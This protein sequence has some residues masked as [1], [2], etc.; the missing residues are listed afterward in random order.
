MSSRRS[1]S[2]S[3][4]PPKGLLVIRFPQP[5]KFSV[6]TF[7]AR[8]ALST[9]PPPPASPGV[10]VKTSG[11]LDCRFIWFS[12]KRHA[13][14]AGERQVVPDTK[15]HLVFRMLNLGGPVALGGREK[16]PEHSPLESCAEIL[17]LEVPLPPLYRAVIVPF[18]S[19]FPPQNSVSLPIKGLY[20]LSQFCR[21]W[22]KS[23][24][25]GV[26]WYLRNF[27]LI[28]FLPWSFKSYTLSLYNTWVFITLGFFKTLCLSAAVFLCS[29]SSLPWVFLLSSIFRLAMYIVCCCLLLCLNLQEERRHQED[30]CW[31]CR[32]EVPN[33]LDQA[34]VPPIVPFSKI[35]L[36]WRAPASQACEDFPFW[37]W[38]T[39]IFFSKLHLAVH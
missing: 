36:Q 4:P 31:A 3:H 10:I 33:I 5:H 6:K 23:S 8:S 2:G 22:G 17:A 11:V 13:E 37:F 39:R 18:S 34:R 38:V 9:D 15:S 26:S 24:I 35:L 1:G 19:P 29:E 14:K 25:L 7:L 16:L 32:G 12:L 30:G 21:W 20:N 27:H 28:L